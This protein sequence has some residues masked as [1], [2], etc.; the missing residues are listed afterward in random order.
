MWV[1]CPPYTRRPT[2]RFAY[3]TWIFRCPSCMMMTAAVTAS[4]STMTPSRT[5]G[6]I[7]P[8]RRS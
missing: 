1:D 2:T 7:S 4:M 8:V 5:R 3:W 6:F